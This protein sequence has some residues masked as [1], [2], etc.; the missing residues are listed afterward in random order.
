MTG[1]TTS[2]FG[3][4]TT[5]SEVLE[6]ID[7]TGRNAIVTGASG[8]LGAETARAL[9]E[10]G[11]NVLLAARDLAKAAP[12]AEA[13]RS[14]AAGRS[15]EVAELDLTS[16]DS[17]RAFAARFNEA[18]EELQLLVNN[19]GIMACPLVRTEQGWE[20]QFATNHLGHFRLTGLLVPALRAGAPS[21]VVIVSSAAHLL[22]PVNFDDVHFER[23]DYDKWVAYAQSKT[24]NVL[25]AREL[26]RRLRADGVTAN[27]LHPGVIMTELARHLTPDDV[28]NMMER[29]PDGAP[30]RF[31]R[32]RSWRVEAGSTSKIAESASPQERRRPA[33]GT[34]RTPSIRKRP[35]CCGASPRSWWAS[36]SNSRLVHP[37][38]EVQS[39]RIGPCSVI[40][41]PASSNEA[42]LLRV[43]FARLGRS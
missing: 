18:H 2:R 16:L 38:G 15:V 4:D 27:A 17:V 14:E 31:K 7:L 34:L 13:I 26:N 11:A 10:K 25:F 32:L 19:A 35:R 20:L 28:K 5:T 29:R 30:F 39:P 37:D 41:C 33:R 12:V 9:A 40:K 21:R 43:S 23:R 22:S 42:S 3:P 8:G 1:S 24:A 6:G 36:A